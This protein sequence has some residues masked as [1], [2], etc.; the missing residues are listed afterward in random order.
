VFGSKYKNMFINIIKEIGNGGDLRRETTE[1][2]INNELSHLNNG[3]TG[4]IYSLPFGEDVNAPLRQ[5]PPNESPTMNKITFRKIL[6]CG[7]PTMVETE[8][9]RELGKE[10]CRAIAAGLF[11][12][13][14]NDMIQFENIA[15]E[16]EGFV[17]L[18]NDE[19]D[20]LV[21]SRV[22][23]RADVREKSTQKGFTFSL[24][25]FYTDPKEGGDSPYGDSIA[26]VTRED[27]PRWS[28]FVFWIVSAT[29]YAEEKHIT[30]NNSDEMPVVNLFGDA[31]GSMF[32]NAISI[33]G[34]Y[35]EMF[36]NNVN[37]SREKRNQLNNNP[38]TPQMNPDFLVD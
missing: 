36:E 1:I 7:V 20:L 34:G 10:Y 11:G 32:E 17:K 16:G 9:W 24:P 31:Y 35:N 21:G 14:S 13:N 38:F 19:V 25:Y 37:I 15:T 6:K 18:Y 5:S 23:L 33:V 29:F 27:D 22:T 2:D 4:L 3:S 26:L 12:K 28:D 8:T 30:K